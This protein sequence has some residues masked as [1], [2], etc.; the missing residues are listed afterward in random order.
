MS[1]LLFLMVLLPIVFMLHDFEEIIMF[2]PWLSRNRDE[3]KTRFPRFEAFLTKRG[4]FD[5][6]TS[7]FALAVCHEFVLLSA[8]R[9]S[10]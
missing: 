4:F 5:Y 1:T 10:S 9:L 6:S 3:L 8:L 2:R 7:A